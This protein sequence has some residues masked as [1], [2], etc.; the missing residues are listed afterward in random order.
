M[1]YDFNLPAMSGIGYR[2]IGHFLRGEL[3]LA[4]AVMQIK[5]ETHRFVRHQ[6]AWFRLKDDRINWF[7]VQRQTDSEIETTITQFIEGK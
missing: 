1:G 6:Y 4:T 5:F 2:Q 7:D 3:N